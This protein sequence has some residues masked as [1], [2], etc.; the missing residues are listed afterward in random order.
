MNMPRFIR[1]NAYEIAERVSILL[2]TLTSDEIANQLF[3][4]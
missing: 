1:K 4:V 3:Y 2:D